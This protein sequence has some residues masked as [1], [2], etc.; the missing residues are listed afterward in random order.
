M[1]SDQLTDRLVLSFVAFV[2]I[3]LVF[4]IGATFFWTLSALAAGNPWAM[5]VLMVSLSLA[6]GFTR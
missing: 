3:L 6:W 1:T 2:V 5:L 4:M